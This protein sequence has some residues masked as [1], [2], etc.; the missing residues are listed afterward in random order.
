MDKLHLPSCLEQ[1]ERILIAGAGGGFDVYT[2]LPVYVRL[3]SL[4][5]QVFLANLSFT[6]LESTDAK[7]LTPALYAVTS[8]TCGSDLYFPESSLAKFLSGHGDDVTIY[9]FAKSG[10]AAIREGYQHLVQTLNLDAI[11]LADGGTDILLRGDEASLGTPAEDMMS[12]AAVAGIDVPTRVVICVGFGVDTYHGV[13]HAN[14]LENVA[15]ITKAGGFLGATALLQSMPEVQLYAEAVRESESRHRQRESIVN[16]SIVSAIEGCFGDYH[17]TQ[18][19]QSSELFI[20]PLMSILWAFDLM[21]VARRNLYLDRL[22]N[23]RSGWDLL[24]AI[25]EFRASIPSRRIQ[26]IP[27]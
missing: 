2:G 24:M 16:G 7:K 15:A 18:R 12:L 27:Y 22:E 6:A 19:T 20:S 13:C 3:K 4:G 23:T 8:T 1:S 5:K 17:R 10:V 14:W 11:V 26:S 25:E 9:A 21:T